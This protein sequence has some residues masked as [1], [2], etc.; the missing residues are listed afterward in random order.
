MKNFRARVFCSSIK[1]FLIIW[2]LFCPLSLGAQP[3]LPVISLAINGHTFAIEVAQSPEELQEGLMYRDDL[4]ENQG[5]LFVFPVSK[6]RRFW[7]K[8]TL[9]SLDLL[10][11]DENKIITA[12]YPSN[13]PKS[14]KSL[15]SRGKAKYALEL[16]GG[17]CIKHNIQ[18]GDS[19]NFSLPS[20]SS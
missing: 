15:R 18:V 12:I 20:L 5:M 7:M 6:K 14:L 13:Q 2:V 8:N 4:S 10:Y 17:T 9:I 16:L 19:V 1:V 11:L 3:Q